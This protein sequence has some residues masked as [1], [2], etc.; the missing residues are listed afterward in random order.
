MNDKFSS[1]FH[2]F[3]GIGRR[4]HSEAKQIKIALE[5][6]TVK[7]IMSVKEVLQTCMTFIYPV[8]RV[9]PVRQ[10]L[11]LGCVVRFAGQAEFFYQDAV[12]IILVMDECRTW[13]DDVLEGL[14]GL[15][16]KKQD[17]LVSSV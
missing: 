7:A 5:T 1:K 14:E 4:V 15:Y 13:S 2:F 6:I 11:Y 16:K 17:S 3:Q 8:Q 10:R 9:F 12:G